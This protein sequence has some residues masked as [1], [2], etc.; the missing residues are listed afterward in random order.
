MM[1]PQAGKAAW[2]KVGI[3]KSGNGH[4]FH[5]SFVTPLLEKGFDI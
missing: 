3:G 2:F 5:G 1:M 4:M